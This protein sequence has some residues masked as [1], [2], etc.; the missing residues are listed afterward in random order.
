MTTAVGRV[1]PDR[2]LPYGIEFALLSHNTELGA[3]KGAC[4]VAEYRVQ[5]GLA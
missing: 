5:R 3:A 4:L 1:R 2:V